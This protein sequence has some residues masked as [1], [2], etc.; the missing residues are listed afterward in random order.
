MVHDEVAR[1]LRL[2]GRRYTVNCRRF[3]GAI[4]RA[5][6]PLTAEDAC[7]FEPDLALST[8]YRV[9]STLVDVGA[10]RAISTTDGV[11]RFELAEDLADHH[12]HLICIECGIIF[13]YAVPPTIEA[14]LEDAAA[15]GARTAGFRALAHRLDVEGIC[16]DCTKGTRS[17]EGRSRLPDR[18]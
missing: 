12:H 13:D 4:L 17:G 2:H 9:A 11:L 5:G 10:L 15:A 18:V 8:V 16:K 3:V 1:V 14:A 7:R 6:R